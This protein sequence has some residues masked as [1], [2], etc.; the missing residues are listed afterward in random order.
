MQADIRAP[1]T[2][3]AGVAQMGHRLLRVSLSFHGHTGP[4]T[5]AAAPGSQGPPAHPRGYW[6]WDVMGRDGDVTARQRVDGELL[7]TCISCGGACDVQTVP[8]G[9]VSL[10]AA[11]KGF[12]TAVIA[13]AHGMYSCSAACTHVVRSWPVA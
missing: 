10:R 9:G 1:Y 8:G 11:V 3:Q 6:K 5:G 13:V 7:A 12:C 4:Y 2:G